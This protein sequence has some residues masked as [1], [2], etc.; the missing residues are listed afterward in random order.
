MTGSDIGR[1]LQG[2]N[3][4]S[5]TLRLTGASCRS[6]EKRSQEE[7][8][9][10][11]KPGKSSVCLKS[12]KKASFLDYGGRE[13]GRRWRL[14]SVG[15]IAR[16]AFS[17]YPKCKGKLWQDAQY[18]RYGVTLLLEALSGL[19]VEERVD[20]APRKQEVAAVPRCELIGESGSGDGGKGVDSRVV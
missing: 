16:R 19:R 11:M 12:M 3:I 18:T 5:K 10:C 15:Q 8:K 9:A 4:Y 17:F 2:A 20:R 7:R 1:A 14:T 6:G 13:C